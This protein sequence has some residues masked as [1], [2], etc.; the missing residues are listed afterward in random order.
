MKEFMDPIRNYDPDSDHFEISPDWTHKGVRIGKDYRFLT[1]KN[2]E[3]I[4]PPGF[5]EQLAEECRKEITDNPD[6][7]FESKPPFI[8][9]VSTTVMINYLN[10]QAYVED[11]ITYFAGELSAKVMYYI[12]QEAI[13]NKLLS[14][15]TS[16]ELSLNAEFVGRIKKNV[17]KKISGGGDIDFKRDD[18]IMIIIKLTEE[19]ILSSDD[20]KTQKAYLLYPAIHTFLTLDGWFGMFE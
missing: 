5:Y 2:G 14:G 17:L 8:W 7:L 18:M 12:M 4:F 10:P 9:K 11:E 13:A 3:L 20:S 16:G 6:S 1:E 15:S 19:R